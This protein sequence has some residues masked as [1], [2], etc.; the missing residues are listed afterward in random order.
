[1]IQ[2]KEFFG[3]FEEDVN[4]WLKKHPDFK[5]IDIKYA[6]YALDKKIYIDDCATC[7]LVVYEI[8]E[9]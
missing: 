5:V 3:D 6:A 8:P 9:K 2:I 7:I 4:K 1:M